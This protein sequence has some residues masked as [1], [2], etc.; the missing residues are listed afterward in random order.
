MRKN[1]TQIWSRCRAAGAHLQWL[2][3]TR[4]IIT[5]HRQ[6]YLLA[7]YVTHNKSGIPDRRGTRQE[8]QPHI[9]ERH[10]QSGP[11][12]TWQPMGSTNSMDFWRR[13]ILNITHILYHGDG[14]PCIKAE[15]NTPQTK[16][17]LDL[18]GMMQYCHFAT[19]QRNITTKRIFA[20]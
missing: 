14:L 7:K 12:S 1:E 20:V 16:H 8:T 17:M 10:S 2:H 5:S 11:Y 13:L 19:E 9:R 6:L 18:Q 3:W 15:G 4:A